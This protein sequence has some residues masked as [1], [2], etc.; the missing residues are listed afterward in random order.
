MKKITIWIFLLLF[1]LLNSNIA[2][3]DT[4]LLFRQTPFLKN[5]ED[6]TTEYQ[7]THST[8]VSTDAKFMNAVQWNTGDYI[9][10]QQIK[11]IYDYTDKTLDSM[12]DDALRNGISS[13]LV[14][15]DEGG[16]DISWTAGIAYVD[17]SL[18]DVSL[19]ASE[20]L[21]DNATNYLYVSK[22]D[23]T[24]NIA[25]S[26]PSGEFALVSIIT[27]YATDIHHK[28]DF[29]AMSGEFRYLL[30]LFLDDV[31]PFA[32]VSGCNITIDTDATNPND[33]NIASG[34]YYADILTETTIA[35]TLY[36][37]GSNHTSSSTTY[38]YHLDSD[39]TT[40]TDLGVD[41]AY[42]DNG[43]ST[44]TVNNVKWYS[45]SIFIEG[46]D[47]IVYVYPQTEHAT[48]A[49]ALAED[50]VYPPYHQRI[51]LPVA[52]FIFRGISTAF[53]SNAYFV[54]R[55]PFFGFT[56]GGAYAQSIYQT[57]TGDSGSTTA[58]ES[59]DSLAIVGG[60]NITTAVT[61]E[62]VTINLDE[63]W[64]TD[65]WNFTVTSPS[66][67]Y[68]VAGSSIPIITDLPYAVTIS[69][70]SISCDADPGTEITGDLKYADAAIGWANPTV[71]NPITTTAGVL[72][73]ASMASGNVAANKVIYYCL[74][75]QPDALTK[76]FSVTIHYTKQ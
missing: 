61:A 59:D 8:S 73:D 14:V 66:N 57:I 41:F 62:T 26:A 51:V 28:F 19:D 72:K 25:T 17:G 33:F 76:F 47:K 38:H 50:I 9:D 15:T 67:T 63:T 12:F 11:D 43:T 37:A 4:S 58:T 71:I 52:S 56:N 69:S 70:I 2:M 1:G 75:S 46:G 64:A 10:A 35:S 13:G 40:S 48:E 6:D 39:W 27:T 42:W 36:S 54:D 29:P 60:T 5:N 24:L 16:L 3:A 18:F 23:A 65:S 68:I 53:D 55:R 22:D 31:I 21:T 49:A 20:T 30:W 44:T 74:H 7:I 32:T 45:A 34:S